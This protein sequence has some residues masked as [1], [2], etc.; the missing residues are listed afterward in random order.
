MG[1]S[2]SR[3]ADASGQGLPVGRLTGGCDLAVECFQ[4][5]DVDLGEGREGLDDIAQ[6]RER[7]AGADGQGCLLQPLAGLGT[8]RVGAG[9]PSPS[10]RRVRKPLDCA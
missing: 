7:H 8:E 5:G 3:P 4:R 1:S 10:L 9:Q 6:H 2:R